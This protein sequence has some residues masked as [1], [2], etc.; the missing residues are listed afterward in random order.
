VWQLGVSQLYQGNFENANRYYREAAP[1]IASAGERENQG[2]IFYLLAEG[3]IL[4][5]QAAAGRA[6]AYR[7]LQLLW[8]FRQSSHL[9]N[10]LTNVAALARGDAM[11]HAALAVMNEVNTVAPGT[12][13]AD[14]RA[15]ALRAYARDLVS[16][17]RTAEARG[18]LAK[19]L[20]WAARVGAG[21]GRER[22]RADVSLVLGELESS[23]NPGAAL[24]MLSGVVDAYRS[25]NTDFLLPYALYRT[26]L[27]AQASDR[28]A[29]ARRYLDQAIEQI[30]RQQAT[31]RTAE[32]RAMLYE[33][34]ETVFDAVI[35]LELQHRPEAAFQYMERSRSVA[36]AL[37]GPRADT[38]D[39]QINRVRDAMPPGMLLVEYALLADRIAVWTVSTRR[40][41]LYQLPVPR[42]SI[43]ALVRRFGRESNIPDPHAEHARATL[44]DLLIRPLARELDGIDRIAVVPDRELHSIAFAALWDSA[45]RK[46]LI[47]RFELRTLPSAAFLVEAS[48]ARAH[49][50]AVR[51]LVVGNPE[52]DSAAGLQLPRLPA[53]QREA[54]SIAQLYSNSRQLVDS[55]AQRDRVLELLP[56]KTVFHFAGH[57][58][59]N[60]EQPDLSYLAMAS[61]EP[62]KSG[63]LLAREIAN[64]RL[65][66]LQLVVL[67][68]CSTLNPRTTRVGVVAGLA[69]SFLRAGVPAIVSS[70][71]DVSDAG[72]ADLL[73]AFHRNFAV[74]G[75]AAAALRAAQLEALK[76]TRS[77]R[78]AIRNWAAFIYT[79]I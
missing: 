18:D 66:N 41:T 40:D 5:G 39:I 15:W 69:H 58:V 35:G 61:S 72:T 70:L 65:S 29:E 49:T 25:L 48:R 63:N 74:S 47:E 54:E 75:D 23:T 56:Q 1:H 79:G 7:G 28:A 22:V 24:S 2:A 33:T 12:G 27:A 10:Q 51:A 45:A 26:A 62:G 11:P 50:G 30:E 16:L 71:W 38:T 13:R 77:E 32:A 4:A 14:L 46:Y 60:S 34:V 37:G 64:L 21:P 76:S 6:E 55:E 57:A 44:F 53:A 3:L 68:A 19:A 42:D 59:F 8:P 31:F 52:V 73:L 43:A 78:R 20:Q 36:R 17:G 9:N 67:A